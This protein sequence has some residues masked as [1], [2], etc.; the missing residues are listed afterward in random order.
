M[1]EKLPFYIPFVF[2]LSSFL[3][4]LFIYRAC[5]SSKTVLAALVAWLLIQGIVGYSGFYTITT[6]LPPRF[7]LLVGP[8]IVTIVLLFMIKKGRAWID[9]LDVKWLTYLHVV[10][11]PVEFVLLWLFMQGQVPQLMTFEGRNFDIFSGLSAGFIA[12]YAYSKPKLGKSVLIGWNL[13]C[14]VLL[15]NIVINAALS[16]PSTFQQQAF[17]QPNVAVLYFP[18]VWLPCFI[19]PV[20]LFSHLVCLRRLLQG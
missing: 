14:M 5:N 7:V 8:A 10:R 1:I 12:Y 15:F 3:T 20:V 4:L 9:T 11:I 18:F 16:A 13:L 6:T 17:G 2:I 19:V